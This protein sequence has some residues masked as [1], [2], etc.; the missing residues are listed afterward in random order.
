MI[1]SCLLQESASC[2]STDFHQHVIL[3][4]SLL[5]RVRVILIHDIDTM[6]DSLPCACSTASERAH[7]PSREQPG[8]SS[9]A[10]RVN[11]RSDITLRKRRYACCPGVVVH[12]SCRRPSRMTN[13]MPPNLLI[14]PMPV[15]KHSS[16]WPA[17]TCSLAKPRR[18]WQRYVPSTLAGRS[19]IRLSTMLRDPPQLPL[20]ES[21]FGGSISSPIRERAIIRNF[22]LVVP[23]DFFGDRRG[24][25]KSGGY[26]LIPGTLIL[27]RRR[28]WPPHQSPPRWR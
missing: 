1:F 9:P 17:Q 18:N 4:P 5:E 27:R 26:A 22:W 7:K 2:L 28:G 21:V 11:T 10:C 19:C 16:V 15:S 6:P 24:M 3:R 8:A 14:K 12:G 23:A 13:G 25:T 20:D